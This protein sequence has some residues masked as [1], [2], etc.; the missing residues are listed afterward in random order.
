M[1]KQEFSELR[2]A[3]GYDRLVIRRIFHMYVSNE[4]EVIWEAADDF[5]LL[6]EERQNR[7]RDILKELL[8]TAVTVKTHPVEVEQNLD[9]YGILNGAAAE[10]EGGAENAVAE[11]QRTVLEGYTHTD[12]YY[13]LAAEIIYDVPGRAEDK[14]EMFDASDVTY[15]ALLGA[16]CPAK[17]SPA[18]LGYSDLD[19]AVGQLE[20]RWEIYKPTAGFLY[21]SFRDRMTDLF[22]A[23]FYTKAPRNETVLYRIFSVREEDV[24][25]TKSEKKENLAELLS[26]AELSIEEAAIVTESIQEMAA[27]DPEGILGK[28]EIAHILQNSTEADTEAFA[29]IYEERISQDIPV[30]IAAEK[31]IK[32]KTESCEVSI[33]TDHAELIREEVIDGMRYVC[34]PADG[35]ITVNGISTVYKSE[36]EAE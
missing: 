27:E 8:S 34:V 3:L 4:N 26:E 36:S 32:I 21:P 12:P 9:L 11:L 28:Q 15:T 6:E 30:T 10:T 25:E 7:I 13:A 19:S 5:Q 16:I 2:R 29:E 24:P 22:E 35:V 31:K 18:A 17:L 23:A 33:Q 14:E 1:I 20:R